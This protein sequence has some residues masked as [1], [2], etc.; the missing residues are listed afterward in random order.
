MRRI[1]LAILLL[2]M[3]CSKAGLYD[4]KNPPI[5]ANRVAVRGVVC[6]EDPELARFPVRVIFVVDQANGDLYSEFDPAGERIVALSNMV[7]SV[8]QRPEYSVAVVG[9][10]PRAKKLAPTDEPFSRNPGELINAINQ[11]SIPEPCAEGG[12][13]RDYNEGIRVAGNIIQDD[14][15]NIAAGER[16]LTQYVVVVVNAGLPIPLVSR[17]NCC[18]ERDISCRNAGDE[19][20]YLCQQQVDADRVSIVRDQAGEAGAGSFELHIMHL[21]ASTDAEENS[22][23]AR[24]HERMAFVGGGRYA[25]AQTSASMDLDDIRLFDRRNTLRAKHFIVTNQNAV[26]EEGDMLADSDGDGLSDR[27]E[28]LAGTDPQDADTDGDSIGDLVE[29]LT[30]TDPLMVDEPDSCS[31]LDRPSFDADRDG[32]SDCDEAVL[33]TEASMVDTDGDGLPDGLE[34]RFGTDYLNRDDV[35]DDDGDGVA[36]GDE[37]REHTDPRVTDLPARLGSAYRYT[38]DDLGIQ[39]EASLDGPEQLTGLKIL[40]VG[41]GSTAGV[42]TFLYTAAIGEMPATL[43]WWDALDEEAGAPVVLQ[44]ADGS[45]YTIP[46]S[47]YAPVQGE[48][49]RFVR[50]EVDFAQLP[51]RDYTERTRVVFRS[52]HCL[53]YTV[54][55]IRLIPTL[56]EENDLTLYFA[57]APSDKPQAAGPFRVASVPIRYIPPAT[58]EPSGAMLNVLDEEFVHYPRRGPQ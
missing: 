44:P 26:V 10:G 20:E 46:S 24:T 31:E 4:A 53:A 23:T 3:G 14:L 52:R 21:A 5:E 13:C 1:G 51:P 47:S 17:R 28:S 34:F 29:A 12:Y 18:A 58:R 43:S 56:S 33:G 45:V 57:E 36:N 27:S 7:N 19:P 41:G 39:T 40:H 48:D 37:V 6:T 55:N 50:L 42:G 38:M 30:G 22:Q 49:G 54:R 35:E 9:Y 25:S 16:G 8:L 15:A 11:L 32:L 2:V